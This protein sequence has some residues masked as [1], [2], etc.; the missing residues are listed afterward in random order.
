MYI[1]YTEKETSFSPDK[2]GEFSELEAAQAKARAIK[3]KDETISYTIEETNGGFNS[4]GEL[5]T[6]VVERG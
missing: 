1:L 3:E 4:Y 6:E 5:L 2:I